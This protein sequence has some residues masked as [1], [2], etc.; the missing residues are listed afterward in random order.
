M[1]EAPEVFGMHANANITFQLA[2][3]SKI[4]DTI[5]F[6]QPRVAASGT[7]GGTSDQ[8]VD[9][10]AQDI[11]IKLPEPLKR[12]GAA[13]GANNPF[14]EKAPALGVVL[15]QEMDRKHGLII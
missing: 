9:R 7:G 5:V 3:T 1:T 15:G 8:I 13:S 6:I 14:S 12:E 2:E 10:I 11:I 4:L